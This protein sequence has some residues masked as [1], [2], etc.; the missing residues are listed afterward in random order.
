MKNH[1]A[2]ISVGSNL[3]HKID[4]CNQGI[5][6]LIR[7]AHTDLQRQS[8]FYQTAPVDFTEQDWFVNAAIEVR[9]E[10]DP[11]LLLNT[12]KSIEVRQGRLKNHIRYGPRILDMDIIFYDHLIV[13][14]PGLTIPHP[15]MHKRRFVLQ[16]V[17]DIDPLIVHPVLKKRMRDLLAAIH[18]STQKVIPITCG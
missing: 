18:D 10:L 9:T 17:C 13:N 1:T 12:L 15:Q 4:N 8:C 3:G 6:M 14:T 16:P 7:E 5:A 2:L 11:Y